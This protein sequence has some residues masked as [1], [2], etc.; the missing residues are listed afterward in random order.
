MLHLLSHVSAISH[1]SPIS[2]VLA[3]PHQDRD[4]PG[5][6]LAMLGLLAVVVLGWLAMWRGWRSR[7][8]RQADVAPLPA[9]PEDAHG[10]SFSAVD[11]LYVGTTYSGRWLERVAA[12][13]LGI[14]AQA[15]VTL[16]SAGVLVDRNGADPLFVPA[17]ALTAVGR[18]S[19]LAGKVVRDDGIV[20]LTWKHG[21]LTLDSGVYVRNDA[22]RARLLQ[23]L[24]ALVESEREAE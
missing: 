19:G 14:R 21:G 24:E 9:V 17:D 4:T 2:H 8:R 5:R 13:G 20:V 22:E 10:S 3:A 1:V 18:S 11:G 23:G 12:Q 7:T 6:I 15:T 16:S